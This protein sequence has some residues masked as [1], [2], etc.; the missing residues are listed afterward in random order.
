MCCHLKCDPAWP[1][2]PAT[3]VFHVAVPRAE[4]GIPTGQQAIIPMT[5]QG[6][7]GVSMAT[8]WNDEE[9]R[10]GKTGVWKRAESDS[11]TAVWVF[12]V[13]PLGGGIWGCCSRRF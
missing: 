1:G 11:S 9:D 2:R 8:Y 10:Y 7:S 6:H 13:C 3:H 4:E 12:L 5:R